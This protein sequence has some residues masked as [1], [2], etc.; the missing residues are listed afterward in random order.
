MRP[1]T[2]RDLHRAGRLLPV[3]AVLAVAAVVAGAGRASGDASQ[4]VPQNRLVEFRVCSETAFAANRC[5]RDERRTAIVSNTLA[6]S[7][8][9]R[10]RTPARFTSRFVYDGE[11]V[12]SDTVRL[13][14]GT[15][16]RFTGG[17]LPTTPMPGGRYGCTFTLGSKRVSA[18]FQSG[19][20]VGSILAPVVCLTQNT[21]EPR[22][23]PCNADESAT[24]L[25]PTNSLT[26]SAV[27]PGQRG[28]RVGIEF[29]RLV[30]GVW[31]SVF[32]FD[33]VLAFPIT[34]E[35]AW[36][37][38]PAGENLAAGE[39]ECRFYLDEQQVAARPFRVA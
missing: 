8:T 5:V 39:W 26:C 3:G 12:R 2:S 14:R 21:D 18:T 17:Y 32:R 15:Y 33:D 20:P 16:R 9:A 22:E 28:N 27:F 4:A 24:P 36:T 34:E 37:S 23:T 10:V 6:C 11:V 1:A 29:L 7:V 31:T 19:G 13:R 25:G 35:W 38:A 30:D